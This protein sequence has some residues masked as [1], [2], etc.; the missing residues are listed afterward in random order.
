MKYVD[1]SGFGNRLQKELGQLVPGR[2]KVK[3]VET[4]ERK[5][6]VWIGGSILGSLST[7][8]E[9]IITRQEYEEWGPNSVLRTVCS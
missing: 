6:S 3:V 2:S 7:Q 4:A 1:I 5:Y 8:K 9:R